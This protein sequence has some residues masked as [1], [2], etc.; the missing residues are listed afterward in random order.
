MSR[1]TRVAVVHYSAT[2]TTHELAQE[3]ATGAEKEGAQDPVGD[4]ALAAVRYQGERVT[5]VAAALASEQAAA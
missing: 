3:I 5:R 1:T 2:G 4:T